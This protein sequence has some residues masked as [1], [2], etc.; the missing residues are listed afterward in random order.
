MAV[1]D[2][3]QTLATT[4]QLNCL[5]ACDRTAVCYVDI[6]A[7][8]RLIGLAADVTCVG[9]IVRQYSD[10]PENRSLGLLSSTIA[11]LLLLLV[12]VS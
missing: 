2:G 5:L 6:A 4:S 7:R 3:P 8:R 10:V 11:Y 1:V 12:C 9:A